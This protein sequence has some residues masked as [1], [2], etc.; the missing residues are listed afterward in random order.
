MARH[1]GQGAFEYILM[2]S[3]VLLV[4]ITITYMMQGS[5]AQADN[6]LDAQM[7]SAGIAL[8]PS[9][10]VPGVKPQFMP[11]S[12]ADGSGST[13]RPNISAAITVKDAALN[14]LQFNWNGTNY[15]VYD[16]SLVLALNFDNIQTIGENATK[17]VDVSAYGNNGAIANLL[18]DDFEDGDYSGWAQSCTYVPAL[19][20]APGYLSNHSFM[21]TSSNGGCMIKY[22]PV[23]SGDIITYA[24]KGN[25][26]TPCI[27]VNSN[28][29]QTAPVCVAS[30]GWNICRQTATSTGNAAMHFYPSGYCNVDHIT[31]GAIPV[32]GKYGTGL[33]FDGFDDWI[34]MPSTPS[35]KTST[36]AITVEAWVRP[37]PPHLDGY[38]GIYNHVNGRGNSRIL[39]ANDGRPLAEVH[40][41]GTNLEVYGP[42]V[43][44]NQW[45]HVAY[46][47]NSTHEKFY[48]NGVAGTAYPK[49][50]VINTGNNKPTVGWGY[51][52]HAYYHFNG[53]IDAVRVWNRSL[54]ADEIEMHYRTNLYKYTPNVWLFDYRNEALAYGTYNYTLYTSGGYRKEG[55]SETR[56]VRYCQVPWPC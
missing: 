23:V 6:T 21:I 27:W 32:D 28:C 25:C 12:P 44:S 42:T 29:Y 16:S 14:S 8:D 56:T 31:K 11:S 38:G 50:G 17:A 3:G 36:S 30:N 53:S 35:I 18:I 54:S 39:L 20:M 48:V 47:Y 41:G 9:Y 33:K 5:L 55:A 2:L 43:A 45:S 4:V 40:I 52:T 13:T 15:T 24:M 46:V 51:S 10:Y 26:G 49:T 19:S 34:E 22:F 37:T 7:K 1:R